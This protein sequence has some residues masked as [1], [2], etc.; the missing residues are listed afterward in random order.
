VGVFAGGGKREKKNRG[1]G[2]RRGVEDTVWGGEKPVETRQMVGLGEK[3][4]VV[5][6]GGTVYY[7]GLG[8]LHNSGERK[9]RWFRPRTGQGK[10]DKTKREETIKEKKKGPQRGQKVKMLQKVEERWNE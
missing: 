10:I 6:G 8:G 5:G 1:T 3:D 4:T 9:S 2:Q 7:R